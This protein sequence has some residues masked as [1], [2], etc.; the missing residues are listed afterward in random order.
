MKWHKP[1]GCACCDY[2]RIDWYRET[3]RI[4]ITALQHG[5]SLRWKNF[6]G[7]AALTKKSRRWFRKWL[8]KN[9]KKEEEIKLLNINSQKTSCYIFSNNLIFVFDQR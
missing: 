4:A 8:N 1:G 5:T 3:N 2:P 6:D 7:D 9:I